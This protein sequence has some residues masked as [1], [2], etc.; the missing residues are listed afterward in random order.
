MLFFQDAH[1]ECNVG[2]AEPLLEEMVKN[3]RSIVQPHIDQIEAMTIE[4]LG[5]APIVPRGGFSWDLRSEAL[6]DWD[7]R[8]EALLDWDLRSEYVGEVCV[9]VTPR[10]VWM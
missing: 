6:L 2:W 8:S 3:P 10:Y 7:L 1:T 9:Y 4:Y 5:G